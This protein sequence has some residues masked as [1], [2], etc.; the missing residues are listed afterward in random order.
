MGE[1]KRD[2]RAKCC[3]SLEA[4]IAEFDT[5]NLNNVE[6]EAFHKY[7]AARMEGAP[8]VAPPLVEESENLCVRTLPFI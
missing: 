8:I 3:S 6:R 5:K 7:N 4:E 1:L 2:L